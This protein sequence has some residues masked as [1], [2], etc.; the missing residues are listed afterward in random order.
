MVGDWSSRTKHEKAQSGKHLYISVLVAAAN[1]VA[2][3]TGSQWGVRDAMHD[4]RWYWNMIFVERNYTGM[5]TLEGK[6]SE[7]VFCAWIGYC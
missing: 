1:M 4:G 2:Q 7:S 3:S 6:K 5:L